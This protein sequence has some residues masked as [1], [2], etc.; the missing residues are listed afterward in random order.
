MS[1]K[2]PNPYFQFKQFTI[3]QQHAA[4][5]VGTD[6]VLLG[7]WAD[8]TNSTRILDIGTGTG[9][10][11]L[12]LAQRSNANVDAVEL[13][14]LACTDAQINFNAS[15]WNDRLKL[16]QTSIQE[17]ADSQHKN[18]DLI[19]CN[20]PF[21]KDSLKTPNVSRNIARHNDSLPTDELFN[22]VIKLL[23][24]DGRFSVIIPVLNQQEYLIKAACFQLFPSHNT[25]VK[26]TPNT[27]PKRVLIEFRIGISGET[28]ADELIVE[29]F[30]R[31]KYSNRFIELTRDFYLKL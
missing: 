28:I 21:F 26:P 9:L 25:C 10:I 24:P 12:M 7:A 15:P 1:Y 22:T 11:A 23:T 4:M 14:A 30:G 18:Y 29:E 5:K 2:M 20:P 31:H 13:D 19:V 3:H 8:V 17:F 16:H 27:E 6:G